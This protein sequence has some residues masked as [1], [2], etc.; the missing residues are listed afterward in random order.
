MNYLHNPNISF[1]LQTHLAFVLTG[2][3]TAIIEDTNCQKVG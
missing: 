3:V 1:C 2:F